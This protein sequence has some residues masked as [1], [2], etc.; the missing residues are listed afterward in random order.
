VLD[1]NKWH[2]A[3]GWA[4]CG[5]HAVILS[6]Y[7]TAEDRAKH[8]RDTLYDGAIQAGRSLDM[9][10]ELEPQEIGAHAQGWNSR[11]LAVC[12]IGNG[13]YTLAQ[14]ES[15]DRVLRAWCLRYGIKPENVLGHREIPGV[16]KDCPAMNMDIVRARLVA[17]LTP[18]TGA[19]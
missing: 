7:I 14:I 16:A 8:R 5:Y 6:G 2:L 12:L 17:A 15:V 4:G 11:S 9:D 18:A 13:I 1:I 19:G 3:R 10:A